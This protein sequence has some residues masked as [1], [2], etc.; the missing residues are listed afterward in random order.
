VT[1]AP[2]PAPSADRPRRS[3]F[4][5]SLFAPRV[6]VLGGGLPMWR[7]LLAFLGPLLLSNVLQAASQA[8]AAVWVGRLISSKALGATSA[9]FPIV[10]LLVSVV[11]G[12]ASGGAVLVAQAFGAG[13]RAKVTRIG[14][15]VLRATLYASVAV[16]IAGFF[17]SSR[18]LALV[19]TPAEIM[20]LADAYVR[21]VFLTVPVLALYGVYTT[22][23]NGT[24]DSV[25]PFTSLLISSAVAVV[26]APF[27]ILGWFGLPKLGVP[28]VA[29]AALIGNLTALTWLLLRLH[30]RD[31]PLKLG[32]ELA[33]D[34]R[35]DWTI[36]GKVARI[37]LPSTVQSS[38]FSVAEIVVLSFINHFGWSATAAYG[39]VVQ[40][41]SYA[42]FPAIAIG[43]ASS[44]F[45]AQCIG[46]RRVQKIGDVV[47]AAVALNYCI[48]VPLVVLCYALRWPILGLFITD[49][50][51]LRVADESLRIILWSIVV[52]GNTAA[53][54]GIMRGSGTVLWPTIFSIASV[55]AVEVPASFVLMHRFG[56]DGVWA[57]GPIGLCAALL[58]NLA[59]Y[60]LV[61]KRAPRERLV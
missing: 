27:L 59:Y 39:A 13:D 35:L 12:A 32:R 24:G 28:A 50:H 18:L 3:G 2:A 51:T 15:T 47:R 43:T 29:V 23:L 46:G 14:A 34:V 61:W 5:F 38:L 48:G 44:V 45:C 8:I 25:T 26:V 52:Y 56:L 55:W 19:G 41:A 1:E 30:R 36:L 11:I 53:L 49:P 9:G 33:G 57:G 21:C 37:G 10:I 4:K 16:A 58:F 7:L 6:D 42:Q 60:E 22:L 20:G 54:T 17:G 31:H 40:V